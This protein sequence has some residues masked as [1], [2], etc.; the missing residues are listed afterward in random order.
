MASQ[1]LIEKWKIPKGKKGE[2]A[3]NGTTLSYT[4]RGGYSLND[5][6]ELVNT[7]LAELRQQNKIGY[8]NMWLRTD[9]VDIPTLNWNISGR[10]RIDLSQRAKLLY[11]ELLSRENDLIEFPDK[12]VIN[13]VRI[14]V[15]EQRENKLFDDN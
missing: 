8:I 6:Q 11:L 10:R 5:A 3:V 7:V 13:E 12:R 4:R 14:M 2:I 15:R 9:E 1:I